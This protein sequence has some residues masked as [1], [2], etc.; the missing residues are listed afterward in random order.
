MLINPPILTFFCAWTA[1]VNVNRLDTNTARK[2]AHDLLQY[3]QWYIEHSHADLSN[4]VRYELDHENS[5]EERL[6]DRIIR[7]YNSRYDGTIEKIKQ[8]LIKT[9]K[10]RGSDEEGSIRY[11][12]MHLIMAKDIMDNNAPR[13]IS[14]LLG[15]NENDVQNNPIICLYDCIITI[16]GSIEEK[17]NQVRHTV[18]Q[19]FIKESVINNEDNYHFPLSIR[20]LSKAGQ[21]P[22]YYRDEKYDI[23]VDDVKEGRIT[24]S[25][26]TD[27]KCKPIVED[28]S[29]LKED[30]G[31]NLLK[32]LWNRIPNTESNKTSSWRNIIL[33]LADLFIK[34]WEVHAKNDNRT[35]Q[36]LIQNQTAFEQ[37]CAHYNLSD[38]LDTNTCLIIEIILG[39]LGD[40]INLSFGQTVE[41]L[42][43]RWKRQVS[44]SDIFRKLD[45]LLGSILIDLV[46]NKFS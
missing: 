12:S 22:V 19:S 44:N 46:R 36:C 4:Y 1:A 21:I 15:A 3:I 9:A 8:D 26:L 32:P 17:F 45:D 20:I 43:R 2:N 23:T 10:H 41:H 16:G 40:A 6:L 30:V 5:C 29:I 14:H 11:A 31:R 7:H 37:V 42:D 24:S 39:A 25:Q 28:L 27:N 34:V 18:R 35:C 38:V 13:S 33:N